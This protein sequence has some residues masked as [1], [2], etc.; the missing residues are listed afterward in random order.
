MKTL[1]LIP[2]TA[3]YCD[4]ATIKPL[5]R[6]VLERVEVKKF[7]FNLNL[8]LKALAENGCLDL[9]ETGFDK[10]APDF[11][12]STEI[13]HVVTALVDNGHMAEVPKWLKREKNNL[14]QYYNFRLT[15]RRLRLKQAYDVWKSTQ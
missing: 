14:K 1:P 3:R 2:L 10:V 15:A 11:G 13:R 6:E 4:E 12:K 7:N 5:H 8:A 9:V